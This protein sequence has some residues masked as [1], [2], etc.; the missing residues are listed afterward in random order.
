MDRE[1]GKQTT[2]QQTE[3]ERRKDWEVGC[4]RGVDHL[5][6]LSHTHSQLNADQKMSN[7]ITASLT[8]RKWILSEVIG[9]KRSV[10]PCPP[11]I[12]VI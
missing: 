9:F 10:A 2:G 5:V 8:N 6:R 12:I 7:E 3:M 4:E 1:S 11:S